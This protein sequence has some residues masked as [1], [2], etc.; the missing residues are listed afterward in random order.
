MNL[1]KA[2]ILRTWIAF[3]FVLLLAGAVLWKGFELQLFEKDKYTAISNE[4]S[5]K[6][7]DLKASRGNIYSED[8]SL[9]ATSV[10]RYEIRMDTEA[11]GVDQD[12]FKA[13]VDS[14]AFKL[15]LAFPER[16]KQEWQRYITDARSRREGYLLVR[17]DVDFETAKDMSSWPFFNLGKYKG[18]FIKIEKNKREIPFGELARRTI[19]YVNES[20][21]KVGIEGTFDSILTG[22][23][24]KRLEQRSY[25]G[26]WKPVKDGNEFEARN[27]LDIY[28]TIDINIQD[29][30]EAALKTALLNNNADHGCAVLMEV[31][32]G[33]IKAIANLKRTSEGVYEEAENYAVNE[34][35][36]PGS[37]FKLVSALALL[38]DKLITPEDTVD[39]EWGTTSFYGQKMED[40]HASATRKLTFA[41]VFEHS[42]NVG[43]AKAIVKAYKNSPEKYVDHVKSL[44]LNK[45][46]DFEVRTPNKP[47]IKSS[48]DKD[49]YATTLPWMSIGYETQIS[50]MQLLA[51]YNAIANNGVMMKPYLVKD[52]KEFG[53]T[54][55]HFDPQILNK[56]VC[57]PETV[58][59]L[60]KLLEGVVDHGTATNLKGLSYTVA[61]KTGTAQIALSAAGYN[62]SSH[63]ASFVGYFPAED[64]QYTCIVVVNA[65]SNGI[66]YGGAVAGPVFKE[67]ADKVFATNLSL[68]KGIVAPKNVTSVPSVKNGYR[69][70]I[71]NVLDKIMISSQTLTGGAE[72]E[73]VT[74]KKDAF[75]IDLK[76]ISVKEGLVPDVSGMGLKDALFLLE[77]GGMKVAVEGYGEV[78]SQSIIPGST[79]IK[80][81]TIL[82]RL[83]V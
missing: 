11:S 76:E 30:A 23:S 49:W 77:K 82:I 63:K 25:G 33:A 75:S 43:V 64:P 13:H 69:L 3:S 60:K 80:G 66:Y 34:F 68:H 19:G 12:Y 62:K 5:T 58:K 29:V 9:I 27:G 46:F 78:Y 45:V 4:Q 15:S 37:T 53:E 14:F 74:T 38:E 39:I 42:S 73:W 2:I 8:G 31:K 10:P 22:V 21:V 7:H 56:A 65:P 55:K 83:K 16:S 47:K 28:T 50:S 71:K 79:I 35:S 44:G 1:K 67:I 20:G 59:Q 36:D 24:G 54:I 81:N 48:K 17:R 70:D 61:G 52:I 51:V 6:W 72:T 41:D 26:V 18:G 32:T 40:A 57:S